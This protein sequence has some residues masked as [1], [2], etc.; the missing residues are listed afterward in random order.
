MEKE[1]KKVNDIKLNFVGRNALK[2]LNVNYNYYKPIKSNPKKTLKT[3]L[4]VPDSQNGYI[5][6]LNT[7]KLEPMHDRN[8]W[9]LVVQVSDYVKPDKIVLQKAQSQQSQCPTI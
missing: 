6:D 1:L 9:D 2:V 5:I 7:K 8:A 4:I 3:A